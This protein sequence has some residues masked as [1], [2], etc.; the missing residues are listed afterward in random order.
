MKIKNKVFLSLISDDFEVIL[1]FLIGSFDKFLAL[2][3]FIVRIVLG[4]LDR[5]LTYIFW[6][7]ICS[8]FLNIFSHFL[9]LKNS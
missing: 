6:F 5:S 2:L 9:A 8:W 4:Q 1:F 7:R 3:D